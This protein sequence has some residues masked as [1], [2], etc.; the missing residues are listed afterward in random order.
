MSLDQT[1]QKQAEDI[2]NISSRYECDKKYW[3]IAVNDLQEKIKVF[4]NAL[5]VGVYIHNLFSISRF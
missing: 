4:G 2:K 5:F 3:T 1:I